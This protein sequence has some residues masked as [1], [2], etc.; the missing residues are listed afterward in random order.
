VTKEPAFHELAT[1]LQEIFVHNHRGKVGGR[2]HA[3]NLLYGV[4][5]HSDAVEPYYG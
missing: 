5:C 2:D 3:H 1:K 4:H